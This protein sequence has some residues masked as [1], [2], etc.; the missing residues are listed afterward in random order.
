L[1]NQSTIDVNSAETVSS[2]QGAV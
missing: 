1:L 2:W